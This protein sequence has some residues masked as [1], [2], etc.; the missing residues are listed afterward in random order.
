MACTTYCSIAARIYEHMYI[1]VRVHIHM[2]RK[3]ER[4]LYYLAPEHAEVS[5]AISP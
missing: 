4:A 5:A 2:Y 1:D 3:I